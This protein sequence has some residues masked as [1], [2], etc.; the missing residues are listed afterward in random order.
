MV[1]PLADYYG[2]N[3]LTILLLSFTF[4]G[5]SHTSNNH[6]YLLI[7][8]KPWNLPLVERLLRELG[9]IF[10]DDDNTK[11][12]YC[13]D[14]ND[15]SIIA[16]MDSTG[17]ANIR[18]GIGEDV[19]KCLNT[20]TITRH[21]ALFTL[22][23][24]RYGV[25]EGYSFTSIA[26]DATKS[27]ESNK[28]GFGIYDVKVDLVKFL[29]NKIYQFTDKLDK[30]VSSEEREAFLE[31]TIPSLKFHSE[32][33]DEFNK[34]N[35]AHT[36][37]ISP[38]DMFI[39][40]LP[41]CFDTDLAEGGGG[42][43]DRQVI[44]LC[45][46]HM[47]VMYMELLGHGTTERA[48]SGDEIIEIDGMPAIAWLEYMVSDDGPLKGFYSDS[49]QRINQAFFVGDSIQ[50]PLSYRS[51]PKKHSIDITFSNGENAT[52]Y[53]LV[54]F[55]DYTPALKEVHGSGLT[56]RTYNALVNLN[57]KFDYVLDIEKNILH[58]D[59]ASI[60][61]VS[62]SS[63][64]KEM[65]KAI[66]PIITAMD[67]IRSPPPHLSGV[68]SG[69]FIINTAARL[70]DK[71]FYR[72]SSSNSVKATTTTSI[73]LDNDIKASSFPWNYDGSIRW[74]IDDNMVIVVIPTFLLSDNNNPSSSNSSPD[75]FLYM[76][77]LFD[78]HHAAREAGIRRILIDLSGNSGG[79]VISSMAALWHFVDNPEDICQPQSKHMTYHWRLWVKSFASNWDKSVEA[80]I[81]SIG[82]DKLGSM[83]YI[84]EKFHDLR[85]LYRY[86]A[87]II[88][89]FGTFSDELNWIDNT[90]NRLEHLTPGDRVKEMRRILLN[91]EFIHGNHAKE[92]AP[93][94]GWYPF[95]PNELLVP[96]EG[97]GFKG[98]NLTEYIH[99]QNLRWGPQYSQYSLKGDWSFCRHEVLP[100][101][102][103]LHSKYST[104]TSTSWSRGYWD[105]IAILSDGGCGSACSMFA[106]GLQLYAKATAYTYG[107][108][109]H[110]P[111]AVSAFT[112]GNVEQYG[113]VWPKV[114][115]AAH[116]GHWAT[117]GEAEW[118]KVNDLDWV[119]YA[120]AFPTR[121]TATFN[122]NMAF[123]RG[124]G[125][126]A[127]PIQ[128]YKIYAHRHI[129]RWA[130]DS[131][132][133][134]SIYYDVAQHDWQADL[135]NPQYPHLGYC[136]STTTPTTPSSH[137]NNT[138]KH[139]QQHDDDYVQLLQQY[140]WP[141]SSSSG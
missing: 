113:R 33:M 24:L 140:F 102:E 1:N 69:D 38:Y 95:L 112:G 4:F 76:P 139:Y 107:G 10:D 121:A 48:S 57:E 128:W 70:D 138:K 52:V 72:I 59:M 90:I 61:N 117:F 34:L 92:I 58:R 137:N 21:D 108:L 118:S 73:T 119:N 124:L 87:H 120:T 68:G 11:I 135:N 54:R 83:S 111:M 7:S 22:H 71:Y 6:A 30:E 66:S 53:W 50:I 81:K 31:D 36:L 45:N 18:W 133:R 44:L 43:N 89:D 12:D 3:I 2:I 13:A 17:L 49:N 93:K 23:N 77:V 123:H 15:K 130:R 134:H 129:S 5:C 82:Y 86:A 42:G 40:T 28:C 74:K 126:N 132:Q 35:D 20:L 37:Y 97:K 62:S 60:W 96:G 116:L 64:D 101:M 109:I 55:L 80:G 91:R 51:P 63:G 65:D 16:G 27:E 85:I 41:I 127:M 131:T 67:S 99:P 75:E 105:N 106:M 136:R 98:P 104:S 19:M 110:H 25:A 88:P 122:W 46:L 100:R 26:K 32:I 79:Y 8:D 9:K 94:D 114:D 14:L 78:I 47:E 103:A 125:P 56:R 141:S 115:L 39:Y 29:D 84:R